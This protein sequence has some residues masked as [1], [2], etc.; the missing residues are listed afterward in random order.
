M[1]LCGMSYVSYIKRRAAWDNQIKYSAPKNK[2]DRALE[3]LKQE[4]YNVDIFI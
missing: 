3:L 1:K 4:W 2:C